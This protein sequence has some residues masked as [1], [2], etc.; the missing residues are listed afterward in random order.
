MSKS[1]QWQILW[2]SRRTVAC[3]RS[4]MKR[5]IR[6]LQLVL[7]IL[8]AILG[9]NAFTSP[10]QN[11]AFDYEIT[12]GKIIATEGNEKAAFTQQY[13][14]AQQDFKKMNIDF[15][16]IAS[17]SQNAETTLPHLSLMSQILY[18]YSQEL[19]NT[20]FY[21]LNTLQQKLFLTSLEKM[22]SEFYSANIVVEL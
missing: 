17:E 1:L 2:P 18:V 4:I 9:L 13:L 3:E 19:K 7:T 22:K 6:S 21:K 11:E 20:S 15:D 14:Q 16:S 5:Q 10:A 12:E 8:L